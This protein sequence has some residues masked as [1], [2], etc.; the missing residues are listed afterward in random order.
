MVVLSLIQNRGVI[1]A[2]PGLIEL[3]G[4]PDIILLNTRIFM[5]ATLL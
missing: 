3:P 1:D 4:L 5:S 2:H